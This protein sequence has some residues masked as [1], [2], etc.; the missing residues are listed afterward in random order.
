M[1]SNYL[2]VNKDNVC[3]QKHICDLIH[4]L[5]LNMPVQSEHTRIV[6]QMLP[7][8]CKTLML[9]T[10]PPSYHK[11]TSKVLLFSEKRFVY[12]RLAGLE[13]II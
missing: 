5:K 3:L 2:L 13:L 7:A 10:P 9:P 8:L 4:L 12:S 6:K 1:P 11:L